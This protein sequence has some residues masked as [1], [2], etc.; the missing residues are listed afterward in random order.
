MSNDAAASR[1]YRR[2]REI[3][4]E[5]L[6]HKKSIHLEYSSHA[7]YIKCRYDSELVYVCIADAKTI[8]IVKI[9]QLTQLNELSHPQNIAMT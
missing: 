9:Q 3:L 2:E 1:M 6:T 4:V 5:T 8:G 7:N